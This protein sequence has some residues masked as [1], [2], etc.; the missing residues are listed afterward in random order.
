MR[1]T[2]ALLAALC[3]LAALPALNAQTSDPI[4]PKAKDW[5]GR[6]MVQ[7]QK[8]L[9]LDDGTAGKIRELY[10]KRQ[11]EK[12]ALFDARKKELGREL[13]PEEVT[14]LENPVH[15]KYNAQIRGLLTPS[16]QAVF[17][18]RYGK[19]LPE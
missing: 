16:Q 7:V 1:K 19:K 10:N 8:D 4:G 15:N 17:D 6:Y 9:K 11:A 3:G 5:A 18:A 2:T 12:R 14:A 13:K